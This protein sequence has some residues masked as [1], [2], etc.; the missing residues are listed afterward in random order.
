MKC[1]SPY[2]LVGLAYS[3][4]DADGN[5]LWQGCSNVKFRLYESATKFEHLIASFNTNTNAW[6]AE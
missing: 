4:K 5:L 3:G 6:V 2:P 1:A